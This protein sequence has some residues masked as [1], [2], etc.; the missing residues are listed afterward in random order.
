MKDKNWK[1]NQKFN[2]Y[3]ANCLKVW[4]EYKSGRSDK[5]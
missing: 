2:I 4:W 3:K 5:K 1:K